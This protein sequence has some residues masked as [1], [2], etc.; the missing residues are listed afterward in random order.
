M[1]KSNSNI[2][3]TDYSLTVISYNLHGFNQGEPGILHLISTVKPDVI[4]IQEH[5]LTP[6][7]MHKLNTLSD[8]Y[9]CFGSSAMETAV[10]LGPLLGRPFGG[11]GILINKS[12]TE[13]VTTVATSDRYTV[14]CIDKWLVASVYFPCVG[15]TNRLDTYMEI[16][17]ELE[18][19][20]SEYPNLNCIIGGDFNIDLDSVSPY[21]ELVSTFALRNGLNR[22]D[23]LY[24]PACKLT[25]C[26]DA[27]QCSSTIDFML[28]SSPGLTVDY[29]I[30]DLDLNMSDH[31]PI[32]VK[33]ICNNLNNI[34]GPKSI[35]PAILT[36]LRWDRAN[37]RAYYEQTRVALEP[38][39][40]D[41]TYL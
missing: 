37:L 17:N 7:N 2:N 38:I 6:A 30:L 18:V 16:L 31:L 24:P 32:I 3:C 12:L 19:I 4:C 11:T 22:C 27:L 20:L 21:A 40:C 14:I 1:S 33:V 9:L 36:Y 28:T 35:Q 34:C 8:D 26:N 23:K 25:Y 5:W 39:L 10:C 29:N 15:T 41:L 13:Y